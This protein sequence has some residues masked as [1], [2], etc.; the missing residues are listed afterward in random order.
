MP[1]ASD[2]SR[3]SM[4]MAFRESPREVGGWGDRQTTHE[5]E[6]DLPAFLSPRVANLFLL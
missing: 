1:E 3:L 5:R 4:S 6:V 2:G